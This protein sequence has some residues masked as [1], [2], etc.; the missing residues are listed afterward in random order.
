MIQPRKFLIF[1]KK[2][3]IFLRVWLFGVGK[4]FVPL[5]Q[6]S[7]K[8]VRSGGWGGGGGENRKFYWEETFLPGKET[9][10]MSDFDNSNLFQS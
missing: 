5:I 1:G 6:G 7:P 4:K 8:V 2:P 9:L 3:E 10:M